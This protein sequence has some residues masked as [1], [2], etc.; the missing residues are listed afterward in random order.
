MEDAGKE[1]VPLAVV[2]T[3]VRAARQVPVPDVEAVND[4]KLGATWVPNLSKLLIESFYIH[5]CMQICTCMYILLIFVYFQPQAL[6]RSSSMDTAEV[7]T[8]EILL[9][10]FCSICNTVQL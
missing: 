9:C 8:C 1:L 6:M 4:E 2:P 7:G 5:A 3:P 10:V